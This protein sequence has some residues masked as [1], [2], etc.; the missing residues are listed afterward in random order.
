MSFK[1]IMKSNRFCYPLSLIKPSIKCYF[2]ADIFKKGS[3]SRFEKNL[4][5]A[6]IRQ[7]KIIT[8]LNLIKQR[9]LKEKNFPI[10]PDDSA[11]SAHILCETKIAN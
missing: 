10:S 6:S 2:L 9:A 8:S 4:K 7:V 5:N 3:S 11:Y 1:N